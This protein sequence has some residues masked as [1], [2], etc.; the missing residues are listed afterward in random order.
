M[1]SIVGERAWKKKKQSK[2]CLLFVDALFV[3]G[4]GLLTGTAT[5]TNN[6]IYNNKS[7]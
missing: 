6:I 1:W 2:A 3:P 7:V 4:L 5:N